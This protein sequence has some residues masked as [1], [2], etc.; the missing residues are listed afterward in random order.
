V[1]ARSI[2]S[3]AG[4]RHALIDIDGYYSGQDVTGGRLYW[5]STP[6]RVLDMRPLGVSIPAGSTLAVP[7]AAP[8]GSALRVGDVAD[9]NVTITNQT[10]VGFVSVYPAGEAAPNA[11][12][13]NWVGPFQDTANRVAVRIGSGGGVNITNGSTGS[14]QVIIDYFGSWNDVI[15]SRFCSVAPHRVFDSRSLNKLAAG[16]TRSLD[17]TTWVAASLNPGC[18]SVTSRRPADVGH[19]LPAVDR[20][21]QS[22]PAPSNLNLQS[23]ETPCEQLIAFNAWIRHVETCATPSATRTPSSTSSATS[24]TDASAH[25]PPP[26]FSCSGGAS[27]QCVMKHHQN[28]FGLKRGA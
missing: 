13:H 19:V 11:S 10:G 2:C 4:I 28:G 12:T 15:G 26:H 16:E 24:T 27:S 6:T 8:P 17:T 1:A 14:I 20:R 5:D 25:R 22:P 3:T 9:I 7:I 18:S 23:G 21:Y